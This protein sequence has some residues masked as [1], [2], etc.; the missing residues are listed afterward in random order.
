MQNT[1]R[2][3]LPEAGPPKDAARGLMANPVR[4]DRIPLDQVPSAVLTWSVC[5]HLSEHKKKM[6]P[7]INPNTQKFLHKIFKTHLIED[8]FHLPLM[9]VIPMGTLNCEYFQI[10]KIIRNCPVVIIR[11]T[12]ENDLREKPDPV[13]VHKHV[14]C[15]ETFQQKIMLGRNTQNRASFKSLYRA[16]IPYFALFTNLCCIWRIFFYS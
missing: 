10:F 12:G 8:F 2:H 5:W 16:K 1:C 11:D 13:K 4:Y 9:S 7:Y 6:Y 3:I 14:H 15:P